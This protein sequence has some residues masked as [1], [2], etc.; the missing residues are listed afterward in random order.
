[1]SISA[2]TQTVYPV[3]DDNGN[4]S[5]SSPAEH[6]LI[7]QLKSDWQRNQITLKLFSELRIEIDKMEKQARDLAVGYAANN[8]HTQIVLLLNRAAELRK[9]VEKYAQ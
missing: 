2:Y 3:E 7:L 6:A 1:M 4:L 5:L 8:N 9:V